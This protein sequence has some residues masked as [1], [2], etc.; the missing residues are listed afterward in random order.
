ML[1]R[2]KRRFGSWWAPALGFAVFAAM[3]SLSAF[4]IGPGISGNGQSE[5]A[6]D[7]I[8][9]RGASQLT[10]RSGDGLRQI[11][12][13]GAGRDMDFVLTESVVDLQKYRSTST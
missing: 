11:S 3:F 9:S 8:S 5:Q 4:V 12:G 6:A 13:R 7:P 1:L 10:A 2:L